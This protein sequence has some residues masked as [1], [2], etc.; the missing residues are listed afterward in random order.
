MF[1]TL[2]EDMTKTKFQTQKYLKTPPN[3]YIKLSHM[4]HYCTLPSVDIN[5]QSHYI[6]ANLD[7]PDIDEECRVPGTS[8]W[9][10]RN[11]ESQSP[12]HQTG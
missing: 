3:L 6:I 2:E 5:G 1:I 11:A 7:N 9:Q 10:D 12:L 4:K 8:P